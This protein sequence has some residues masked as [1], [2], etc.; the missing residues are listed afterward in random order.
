M[1]EFTAGFVM[2]MII[3]AMFGVGLWCAAV[4]LF[5]Q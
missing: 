1:N 4:Q 5:G 2:G 3:G